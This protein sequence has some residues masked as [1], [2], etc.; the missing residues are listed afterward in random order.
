VVDPSLLLIGD[1]PVIGRATMFR[2]DLF[3]DSRS[4]SGQN[5]T[6]VKRSGT[7]KV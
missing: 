4:G 5:N 6:Q 2:G 1:S 3:I 7:R